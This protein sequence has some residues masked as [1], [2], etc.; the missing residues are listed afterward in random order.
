MSCS[1]GNAPQSF[2]VPTP[3]RD[4]R[5]LRCSKTLG[6]A[7]PRR[8]ME[9]EPGDSMRSRGASSR[10]PAPPTT[11]PGAGTSTLPSCGSSGNRGSRSKAIRLARL[12]PELMKR[13]GDEDVP[14]GG[15]SV[16][17]GSVN[18]V[19]PPLEAMPFTVPRGEHEIPT[20][21]FAYS[22]PMPPGR[23]PWGRNSLGSAMHAPLPRGLQPLEP[24]N[25]GTAGHSSMK[26][27]G[28]VLHTGLQEDLGTSSA[29]SLSGRQRLADEKIGLQRTVDALQQRCFE[30]SEALA[31]RRNASSSS[32]ALVRANVITRLRWQEEH[33]ASHTVF[34]AWRFA[35]STA[36]RQDAVKRAALAEEALVTGLREAHEREKIAA[37]LS[38]EREALL[39]T[40]LAEAKTR[41]ANAEARLEEELAWRAA[42]EDGWRAHVEAEAARAR[43]ARLKARLRGMANAAAED[44]RLL[45]STFRGWTAEAQQAR[46]RR[47][48]EGSLE[49]EKV[50]AARRREQLQ[51]VEAVNAALREELSSY[52]QSGA[53]VAT[54][55]RAAGQQ[56]AFVAIEKVSARDRAMLRRDVYG[57]FS[58]ATLL[59]VLAGWRT[60]V[61]MRRT[62]G[63][64]QAKLFAEKSSRCAA[65]EAQRRELEA[66]CSDEEARHRETLHRLRQAEMIAEA[67]AAQEL[68]AAQV[69]AQAG[70]SADSSAAA[71]AAAVAAALAAN[72][73]RHEV[74]GSDDGMEG[75]RAAS[76]S[77][78][79]MEAA[80]FNARAEARIA[81]MEVQHA[82]LLLIERERASQLLGEADRQQ[83]E[84]LRRMQEAMDR[85]LASAEARHAEAIRELQDVN[86]R[87][88]VELEVRHSRTVR[89]LQGSLVEDLGLDGSAAAAALGSDDMLLDSDAELGTTGSSS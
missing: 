4:L 5:G 14:G 85:R 43:A 50:E 84:A 30:L 72:G 44:G 83:T 20:S 3:P 46:W 66:R 9:V 1:S 80:A 33:T 10:T 34:L 21:K 73:L 75:G 40:Q 47:E 56:D 61:Y 69:E 13:L 63:S 67:K 57:A 15:G 26:L 42:A 32:A 58:H 36:R 82:E 22:L 78:S 23:H 38:A 89:A 48:L 70:S 60:A 53:E 24:L 76:S 81:E 11:P 16:G 59:A 7:G 74:D 28:D 64:V 17:L 37:Q 71:A 27:T 65:L 77:S 41:S 39:G 68:H 79:R 87:R 51:R 62:I 25:L 19:S 88:L 49:A 35:A 86:E 6:P 45:L 52:G 2:M 18:R 54:A 31:R 8:L 55:R 12:S 29:L